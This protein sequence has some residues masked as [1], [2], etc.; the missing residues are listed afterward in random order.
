MGSLQ[1][2]LIARRTYSWYG[3]SRSLS[4]S[5][6]DCFL[7]VKLTCVN[8]WL[9]IPWST[10]ALILLPTLPSLSSITHTPSL[11]DISRFL[12]SARKG[13]WIWDGHLGVGMQGSLEGS[14]QARGNLGDGLIWEHRKHFGRLCMI[15]VNWCWE[16]RFTSQDPVRRMYVS[17]TLEHL[18]DLL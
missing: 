15:K 13:A 2:V 8:S 3:L 4:L 16:E 12:P 10:W 7:F 5:S 6:Q 9:L 18:P 11:I 17:C 1:E 14:H